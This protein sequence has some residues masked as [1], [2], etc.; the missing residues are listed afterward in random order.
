VSGAGYNVAADRSLGS[1]WK[2]D[3]ATGHLQAIEWAPGAGLVV[4]AVPQDV[5]HCLLA[6]LANVNVSLGLA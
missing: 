5:P 3:G 6:P 2:H 4:K 1:K